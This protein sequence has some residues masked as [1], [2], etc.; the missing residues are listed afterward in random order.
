MTLKKKPS[1]RKSLPHRKNNTKGPRSPAK[2]LAKRR[3]NFRRSDSHKKPTRPAQELSSVRSDKKIATVTTTTK[4]SSAL[5]RSDTANLVG[6]HPILSALDHGYTF[7]KLYIQKSLQSDKQEFLIKKCKALNIPFYFEERTVLDTL[8]HGTLHQGLVGELK[9]GPQIKPDL[10]KFLTTLQHR[11]D[12][13]TSYQ[14]III[15]ADHITDP[16][17]LGALSRSAVFFGCDMIVLEE[18]HTAP[19]E[20]TVHKTSAGASLLIPYHI[21]P[22]LS[23]ALS[24]L[25]A[26][27]YTIIASTLSTHPAVLTLQQ[28]LTQHSSHLA[29]IVLLIGSEAQGV[30]PHLKR[31][32]DLHVKITAYHSAP[33][34]SLN[35]SVATGI[36]LY[37]LRNAS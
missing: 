21:S 23:Q 12:Q 36:L 17:N 35:L 2:P 6:Y 7:K 3:A 19:L 1:S 26:A 37:A 27:G 32:S 9:K 28:L 33:V 34:N 13:A 20:S 10:A 24:T 30:R 29:K 22:K 5:S 18:K 4:N 8:A 11:S 14:S 31:N 15:I 25:K 16:R